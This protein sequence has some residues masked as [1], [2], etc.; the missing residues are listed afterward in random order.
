MKTREGER[1]WG[2]NGWMGEA[3]R[4]KKEKSCGWTSGWMSTSTGHSAPPDAPEKTL[5]FTSPGIT[6]RLDIT[7]RKR[8]ECSQLSYS[9]LRTAQGL[10][11]RTLSQLTCNKRNQYVIWDLSPFNNTN[12]LKFQLPPTT[13]GVLICCNVKCIPTLQCTRRPTSQ[14]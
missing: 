8:I 11:R 7:V 2:R 13:E 14:V 4:D 10:I 5:T 6:G 9:Y 12:T 1:K 3:L